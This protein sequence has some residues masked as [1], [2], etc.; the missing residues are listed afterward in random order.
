MESNHLEDWEE[1]GRIL[2]KRVFGKYYEDVNWL[3]T[4][5][6]NVKV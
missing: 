1:D 6:N 2:L 3:E 5:Q 4:P